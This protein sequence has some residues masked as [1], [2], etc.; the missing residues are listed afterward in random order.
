MIIYPVPLSMTATFLLIRSAKIFYMTEEA[1]LDLY[2][3][4]FPF[5]YT[6]ADPPISPETKPAKLIK[7]KISLR[8]Y[9]GGLAENRLNF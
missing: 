3:V 8:L 6:L 9:F 2:F 1:S 5:N 4:I 7:L